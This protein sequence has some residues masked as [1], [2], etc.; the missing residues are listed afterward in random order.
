MK[1][2]VLKTL[3]D[4]VIVIGE[5]KVR[6][7]Y[8]WLSLV[9]SVV[10]VAGVLISAQ[11]SFEYEFAEAQTA[12]TTGLVAHWKFDEGSG[13]TALDSSGNNNTG[14]LTNGPLWT[15]GKIGGA[16]NFDGVNDYVRVNDPGAGSVLDLPGNF[17]ISAWAKFDAFPDV[18]PG[19]YPRI[20]QKG[21]A[22]GDSGTWSLA[23]DTGGTPDNVVSLAVNGNGFFA[24]GGTSLSINTWYH[25][26]ATKNGATATIFIN[27]VQDGSVG[28][29]PSGN[30][31][32]NNAAMDFGKST[33]NS[34]GAMDGLIDDVRIYNRAL[35][36]QEIS[37]IYNAGSATTQTPSQTYPPSTTTP[38]PTVS[39]SASPTSIISGNSSTLTWTSTNAS[40]CTASGGWMGIKTISGT[41]VL[42]PTVSTTYTLTCSGSGGTI[43]QSVTVSV[44]AQVQASP[45]PVTTA[46]GA[47]YPAST[48]ITGINF[49]W[50]THKRLAIGSDNW[51]IT[52]ADDDNQY[53]S[54]GDGGG[55]GGADAGLGVARI[56]GTASNY[57]G[58]N[59][60]S[61]PRGTAGGKSYGIISIGGILYMWV[62]PGSDTE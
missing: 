5:K 22:A 59:L 36:A 14:T 55:F 10:M 25:I 28:T 17:T 18:S 42:F 9:A 7:L 56:S 47:P 21:F 27:G 11:K 26:V 58:T 30:I 1:R 35:S 54:W 34:D 43:S 31:D 49:N 46:T 23:I 37:D 32:S 60:W 19:K 50:A 44:T 8:A 61:V 53:T 29:F 12:P 16:L 15:T 51:P 24:R 45:P 20:V 52:W 48:A 3:N 41:E 2:P 6:C 13:T 39:I 4:D 62:Q 40:S 38:V 57:T 33:G